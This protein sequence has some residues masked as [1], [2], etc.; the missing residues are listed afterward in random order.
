MINNN[1]NNCCY[2][3]NQKIIFSSDEYEWKICD[4]CDL[5]YQLSNNDKFKKVKIL[6][7]TILKWL[8][9]R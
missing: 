8:R 4:N 6:I 9:K 2:N 3:Y 5:I 1:T 7:S